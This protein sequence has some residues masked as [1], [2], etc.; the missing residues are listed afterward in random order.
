[1]ALSRFISRLGEKALPLYRLLRR[2]EHFEWTNAAMA[3]LEEIKAILATNPI[4]VV[5]N[6]GELGCRGHVEYAHVAEGHALADEVEVDLHVL[7]AL[8]LYWVGGEVH[9][10]DVVAVDDLAFA[11]GRCSS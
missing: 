9:G 4:L 3:G 6:V 8:V 1:M 10:A 2:T 11:G 5:P 7:G